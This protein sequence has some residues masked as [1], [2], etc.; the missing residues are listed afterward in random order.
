MKNTIKLKSLLEDIE[1]GSPA[2]DYAAMQAKKHHEKSFKLG[3]KEFPVK[4][5]HLDSNK[6]DEYFH[7]ILGQIR[8]YSRKLNSEET[9]KLHEKLK[10]FFEKAI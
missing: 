6:V 1:E 8:T 5:E 10:R 4:E 3:G 2:F 7:K 9:Y